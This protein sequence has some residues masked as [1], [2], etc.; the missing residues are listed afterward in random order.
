[1]ADNINREVSFKVTSLNE[2]L[3]M[4]SGIEKITFENND[5]ANKIR[6]VADD[7]AH[8]VDRFSDYH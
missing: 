4:F 8:E 2:V 1:M 3:N 5:I 7:L 6:K